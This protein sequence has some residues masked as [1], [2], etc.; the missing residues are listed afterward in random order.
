MSPN[1][2]LAL[3]AGVLVA[4]G[5]YLVLERSLTR[6][7]VRV[8]LASNG[9]NVLF[10]VAS[11]AAGGDVSDLAR[12]AFGRP[13]RWSRELAQARDAFPAVTY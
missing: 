3:V 6:I 10:L 8:L 1:L 11:G 5:V 9:V 12:R 4:A 7:L 2:T 13:R